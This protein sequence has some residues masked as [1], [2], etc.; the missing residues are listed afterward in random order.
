MAV[1]WQILFARCFQVPV[2]GLAAV[3]LLL[4][5]WLIYAADRTIDAWKGECHSPRHEFYS[6]HWRTLLPVW[7]AVLGLTG[8]LAAQCLSPELFL[9]GAVLLTAVGA[10]FALVHTGM[11]RCPKEVAVGV[12][13]ALGASLVAWGKVNT[14][15]DGATILLFS[16]LCWM[17]CVAI[18]MWEG[19]KLDWSPR[20][21]AM[22]LASMAGVLLCAHRPILGGAELASAFAFIWLD[23]VHRRFSMDAVRVL[24]DVALLSPVLF[25]PLA[26]R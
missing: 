14:P 11:L 26:G 8:C 13:F 2:D 22:V 1:L 5:V 19:E 25:L 21:A 3:L 4:T 17:N 24:A 15:A 18:Q 16:G 23:R 20:S 12:L 7:F 9:R 10:Y 6:R